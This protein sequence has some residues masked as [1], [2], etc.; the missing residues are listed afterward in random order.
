METFK[1]PAGNPKPIAPIVGVGKG[2][3]TE[4]VDIVAPVSAVEGSQ[5]DVVVKIKNLYSATIHIYCVALPDS[6][7]RFIDWQD[8]W[9]APGQTQSF[10]GSFIMGGGDVTIN[11]YSYFEG[12][13]GYLYHDDSKS[14]NVSV[15]APPSPEF[16]GF[17]ISDYSK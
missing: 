14:K 8:A 13:D 2:T 1:H 15:T 16:S 3:Y 17:V 4:I 11:A 12:D 5:V 9:V 6:A 10:Y 7:F